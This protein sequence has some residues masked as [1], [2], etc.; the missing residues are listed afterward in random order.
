[1]TQESTNGKSIHLERENFDQ[2]VEVADGFWMIAT[3]HRPG[4][5]KMQP[6]LDSFGLEVCEGN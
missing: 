3:R 6:A 1:M 2:A 4:F 5:L